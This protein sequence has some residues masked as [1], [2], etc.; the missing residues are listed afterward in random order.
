MQRRKFGDCCG[1]SADCSVDFAAA[2]HFGCA[3]AMVAAKQQIGGM[4]LW[5]QWRRH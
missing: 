3:A 4:V 1:E 2:I 5:R